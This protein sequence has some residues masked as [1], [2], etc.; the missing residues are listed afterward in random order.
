MLTLKI[1]RIHSMKKSILCAL[2]TLAFMPLSA[3][4]LLNT[5]F[6]TNGPVGELLFNQNNSGD[7]VYSGVVEA[8]FSADTLLG[9]AREFFYRTA[10]DGRGVKISDRFDGI[11]MVASQVEIPVGAKLVAAPFAG[12]WVKAASTV[13]FNLII[14]LRPGKFRYTL[15]GFQTDRWRIPGEGKDKGQSNLLHW[16]RINSLNKE[17][18]KTKEKEKA[19]I[20]AM[21]EKE[22][23]S[24][25]MEYEAVMDFI[26]KLKGFA[27]IPEF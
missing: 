9:L 7:I 2:I 25:K 19:E 11:T 12:A 27:I 20:E 6:D 22:K 13:K 23:E 26:E 17:M 14:D 5:A 10:N 4:N 24:Y 3:Q 8:P 1:N 21:I 15:S 18:N 16:H